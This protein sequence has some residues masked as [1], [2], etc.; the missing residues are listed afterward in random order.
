MHRFV[1]R[2]S[3]RTHRTAPRATTRR[4]LRALAVSAAVLPAA[5]AG[6]SALAVPPPGAAHPAPPAAAARSAA[7]QP[8]GPRLTGSAKLRRLDGDDVRCSFDAHFRRDRTPGDARGTFG[9]RHVGRTDSGWARGRIDCLVTGGK[10][11]TTGGIVTETD[12]PGLKGERVGFSV[13]DVHDVRNTVGR[14]GAD[15][16]GYRLGRH[17]GPRHH[18]GSAPVRQCGTVRDGGAR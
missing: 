5:G 11:A 10:A 9:F 17:P 7:H 6:G 13:R 16:L 18:Q 14:G 1:H 3:T 4:H 8:D 15:R 12:I 2:H